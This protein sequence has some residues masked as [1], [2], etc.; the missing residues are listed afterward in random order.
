ME[1]DAGLGRDLRN[2]LC[3]WAWPVG[4]RRWPQRC[5]LAQMSSFQQPSRRARSPQ[6]S[7]DYCFGKAVEWDAEVCAAGRRRAELEP[8]IPTAKPM[9]MA[10]TLDLQAMGPRLAQISELTCEHLRSHHVEG[11]TLRLT[12]DM[13]AAQQVARI[14]ELERVCCAFLNFDLKVA[15]DAV[16]LSVVA[17][18]QEGSDAQWLFA[19]F[20]PQTGLQAEPGGKA[21]RC[22]CPRD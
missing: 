16:E 15:A 12:Y 9:P 8:S 10:C 21:S 1:S 14:V 13:A 20:L 18:E 22:A 7:R 5:W 2:V 6:C 17:P 19:Q 4:S 3:G 11:S